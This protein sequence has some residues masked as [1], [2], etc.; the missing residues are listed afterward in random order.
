MNN[1]SCIMSPD[2]LLRPKHCGRKESQQGRCG[3]RA[4]LPQ[5]PAADAPVGVSR[6]SKSL[7]VAPSLRVLDLV[8]GDGTTAVPLA[9]LGAGGGRDRHRAEPQGRGRK[10]AASAACPYWDSTA[11]T[12]REGDAKQFARMSRTVRSTSPSRCLGPCL[13]LSPSTWPRKWSGSPS[14]AVAS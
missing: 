14:R 8:C 6:S 10:Q 7:G 12:F 11:F 1:T 4:T 9:Q 5:L 3:K 13:R 2:A